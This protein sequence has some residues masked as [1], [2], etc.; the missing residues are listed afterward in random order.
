MENEK[1]TGRK[2]KKASE[3]VRVISAYLTGKEQTL[4]NKKYGSVTKALREKV[5]PELLELV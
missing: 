5:L 2:P 3:R 4:I 1:R